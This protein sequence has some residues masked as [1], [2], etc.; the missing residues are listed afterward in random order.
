MT[1]TDVSP[2]ATRAVSRAIAEAKMPVDSVVWVVVA[3][4]VAMT[5]VICTEAAAM[6]RVT[7]L[8][9]TPAPVAIVCRMVVFLASS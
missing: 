9:A 7:S 1:V 2:S 6:V 5:A 4:G 8:S 3:S